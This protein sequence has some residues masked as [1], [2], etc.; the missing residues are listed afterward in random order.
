MYI[1]TRRRPLGKF[2]TQVRGA[3]IGHGLSRGEIN[4]GIRLQRSTGLQQKY[5]RKN[6][7]TGEVFIGTRSAFK[8]KFRVEPQTLFLNTRRK[9]SV[10]DWCLIENFHLASRTSRRD[11]NVY[12]VI[13]ESG[14][15]YEG[16]RDNFTKTYGYSI[17]KL[18]PK[19]HKQK[20]CKGWKLVDNYLAIS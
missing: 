9:L 10:R 8:N 1:Y 3:E 13:H 7:V 17:S 15:I 6:L 2:S 20:T 14:E 11:Y 5:T 12:K 18:F 4:Y 19:K 16:T